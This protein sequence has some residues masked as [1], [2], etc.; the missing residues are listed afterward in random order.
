[1][2]G[3]NTYPPLL[4]FFPYSA[5]IRIRAIKINQARKRYFDRP[6]PN[7]LIIGQLKNIRPN[8]KINIQ[9]SLDI[10]NYYNKLKYTN[11]A[12]RQSQRRKEKSGEPSERHETIRQN[13]VSALKSQNLSVRDIS[14]AVRIPEKEVYGH[15]YHIKKTMSKKHYTFITSP[16]K[17]KKC[18][19]VF[20]KRERL[21]RPGKCPSCRGESI[22]GPFFSI[23]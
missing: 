15:L 21:E 8:R 17:C 20:R 22:E 12:M 3:E 2:V 16:A 13:I 7:M 4:F 19:F 9:T 23:E 14:V 6:W 10:V 18:G 5:A 1:M 11:T